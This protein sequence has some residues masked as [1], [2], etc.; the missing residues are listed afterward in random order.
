LAQTV[1]ALFVNISALTLLQDLQPLSARAGQYAVALPGVLA[2]VRARHGS[3]A[4][5]LG[6]RR[7]R[8]RLAA[9]K[10]VCSLDAPSSQLTPACVLV[11]NIGGVL[12]WNMS[13]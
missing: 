2:A 3:V 9:R 5:V 13:S 1:S 7:E 12:V 10:E 6:K 8:R 4:A 11:S